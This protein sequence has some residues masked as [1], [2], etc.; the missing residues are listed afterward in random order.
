VIGVAA[1]L[2]VIAGDVQVFQPVEP[3]DVA[4]FFV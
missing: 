3:R 2:D 1:N 4:F